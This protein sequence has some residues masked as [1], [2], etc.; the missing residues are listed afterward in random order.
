MG[1]LDGRSSQ[2]YQINAGVP[3]ECILGP[4]LILLYINDLP[5]DVIF[6]IAIYADDPTF[7]AKYDLAYDP[8]QQLEP[9]SQVESYLRGTNEKR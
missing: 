7:Y 5:D 2:D 1:I 6:N 4:T 8:W 9:T 3:T